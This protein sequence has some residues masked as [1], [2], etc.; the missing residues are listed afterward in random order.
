M[1]RGLKGL[2]EKV[3]QKDLCTACGACLSLCPYLRSWQGRVWSS[4]TIAA[5]RKAV[6][7][8]IAPEQ[9]LTRARSNGR[10]MARIIMMLK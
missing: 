6:V 4:F 1:N 2:E 3:F 7:L 10:H 9:K 5:S 8:P